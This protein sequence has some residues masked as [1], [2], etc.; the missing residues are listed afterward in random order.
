M[1][2]P[3]VKAAI[4]ALEQ[5][6]VN[7]IIPWV[8]KSAEK[9]LKEAFEK[10]LTNR[11]INNDVKEIVDLWF[12]ETAVRLHR[13]G[14]GKGFK[15]LKPAGLDWGPIV[16]KAEKAIE[17]E[18]PNEVIS[19]LKQTVEEK[20]KE[21]FQ[22]AVNKKNFDINDTDKARNYVHKMLDFILFSH[23]LYKFIIAGKAHED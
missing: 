10:T 13:L 12:F 19:F 14:E 4:L 23:H 22:N 7:L 2:G 16:P 20:I 17:F 5:K 6:N 15:G 3:V 1:D 8:P 9:E 11:E 21:K 18:N